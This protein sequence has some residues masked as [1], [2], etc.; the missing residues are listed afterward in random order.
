M[1]CS[2]LFAKRGL[3]VTTADNFVL[4]EYNLVWFLVV[5]CLC[6][7][8]LIG[9]LRPADMP[10]PL[11]W[12][13]LTAVSSQLCQFQLCRRPFAAACTCTAV[14][15]VFDSPCRAES[16]VLALPVACPAHHKQT[17]WT[18]SIRLVLQNRT[19]QQ[20]DGVPCMQD[21]YRAWALPHRDAPK[22]VAPRVSVPFDAETSYH[23]TYHAHPLEAPTRHHAEP[24]KGEQLTTLL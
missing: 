6:N 2:I 24:W 14:L 4:L 22:P 13:K 7:Q 8:R 12:T 3:L 15:H 21:D 18:E 11:I 1:C 19:L 10:T 23:D 17:P 20:S 5:D 9:M 16:A